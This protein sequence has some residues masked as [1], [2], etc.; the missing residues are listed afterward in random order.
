[1]EERYRQREIDSSSLPPRH[2]RPLSGR[3]ANGLFVSVRIGLV[4]FCRR[5]YHEILAWF[6]LGV[7]VIRV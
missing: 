3:V 7:V 5:E 6:S 2:A 1:M 4:R